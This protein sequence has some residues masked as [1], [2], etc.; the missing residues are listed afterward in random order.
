MSEKPS[1]LEIFRQEVQNGNLANG[2]KTK[3]A[4]GMLGNV[5]KEVFE[6][7]LKMRAFI[8]AGIQRLMEEMNKDN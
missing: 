4:I 6:S 2:V 7:E 8:R 5:P 1:F 3:L